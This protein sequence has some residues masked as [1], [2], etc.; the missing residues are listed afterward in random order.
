MLF[1]YSELCGMASDAVDA[2]RSAITQDF[3]WVIASLGNHVK[4]SLTGCLHTGLAV[5]SH[6][7]APCGSLRRNGATAST[8]TLPAVPYVSDARTRFTEVD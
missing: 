8:A 2:V 4:K 6:P 1:R 3:I 5:D 7:M